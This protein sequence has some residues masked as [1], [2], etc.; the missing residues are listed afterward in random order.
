MADN[1]PNDQDA[2][3]AA[4]AVANNFA[5]APALVNPTEMIDYSTKEGQQLFRS[6]VAK[7][8]MIFDGAKTSLAA[9]LRV[10]KDR[11]NI[12]GWADLWEITV[13]IDDQGNDIF[14]NLLTQYAEIPLELV[15]EN[16]RTD[17]LGTD[18]RN[19]QMSLQVYQCLT[20]SVS[21]DVAS[22]MVIEQDDFQLQSQNATPTDPYF[23][24]G[25]CYLRSL[26]KVY[27]VTTE[28]VPSQIRIKMAAAHE[29]IVAKQYNIDDFNAS[30]AT[31]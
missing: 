26:I 27:F 24:D 14:K 18:S 1:E 12:C 21:T 22:R 31:C 9:F 2:A 8:P 7:L 19:A 3:P 29:L 25:P 11:S 17:Y 16:A 10:I 23:D 13:D 6:A 20:A 15:Q 30:M 4:P 5:L 28:A